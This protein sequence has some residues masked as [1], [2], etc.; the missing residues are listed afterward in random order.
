MFL[1]C[2]LS[3]LKISIDKI[4][5]MKMNLL[6]YLMLF[7]AC[8][9]GSSSR[10]AKGALV[11]AA[12]QENQAFSPQVKQPKRFRGHEIKTTTHDRVG[13]HLSTLFNEYP[14]LEEPSKV[15]KVVEKL[16]VARNVWDVASSTDSETSERF[17]QLTR[18]LDSAGYL[19]TDPVQRHL[20]LKQLT[21]GIPIAAE[22]STVIEST[23]NI[24][25]SFDS[26]NSLTELLDQIKQSS[27]CSI[28]D[29]IQV[30][31]D[32]CS[33]ISTS[34]QIIKDAFFMITHPAT[35]DILKSE[36]VQSP[37]IKM[38]LQIL[39]HFHVIFI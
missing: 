35:I 27:D 2:E 39:A 1:A 18:I 36:M 7:K 13:Y 6:I 9:A 38:I 11:Y 32:L 25:A 28:R 24:I 26:E 17:Q 10:L 16:K 23:T 33:V 34:N 15:A 22:V 5:L 30:S 3:A 31:Q 8:F 29:S 12:I 21:V 37:Y 14:T 19:P 20:L 4:S